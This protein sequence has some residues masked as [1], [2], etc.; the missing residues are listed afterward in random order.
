MVTAYNRKAGVTFLT[1]SKLSQCDPAPAE[2]IVHLDAG[3][4]V[5]E[6][7][8][9]NKLSLRFVSFPVKFDAAAGGR[10]E[11]TCKSSQI[12]TRGSFDDDSYP[13]DMDYFAAAGAGSFN[14]FPEAAIV[15]ASVANPGTSWAGPMLRIVRNGWPTLSGVLAH[16]ADV[17][18]MESLAAMCLCIVTYGME[19]TDLALRYHAAGKKILRCR[20][21]RVFHDTD[22]A[23]Q[24]S[25]P[26]S[27]GAVSNSALQAF[28][29]YPPCYWPLGVGQWL[30]QIRW[31]ITVGSVQGT[32]RGIFRTPHHLVAFAKYR[33]SVSGQILRSYRKLVRHP[34]PANEQVGVTPLAR[35]AD[36]NAAINVDR[37]A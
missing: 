29:R 6:S 23:H 22:L 7:D 13:E 15:A 31:Q 4:T 12:R 8:M 10:T 2:I 1:L 18:F 27:A 30:N 11:Q 25:V 32:L 33:R 19:E 16:T 34:E 26:I 20:N 5:K 14:G 9:I 35:V 17:L 28:L 37:Q 36:E 24:F 3:A 21:L